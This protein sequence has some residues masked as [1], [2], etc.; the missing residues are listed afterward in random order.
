MKRFWALAR[1]NTLMA[2][3]QMNFMQRRRPGRR[4][5]RG[6]L[7]GMLAVALVLMAY[8]TFWA[9][10][11]SIALNP[12]GLEWVIL[13]IGLVIITVLVLTLSMFTLDS[14][15][16]DNSDT[17]TLFAYP[18]TKFT[19]V[20]GKIGGLLVQN[21]CVVAVLWLPYVGVYA[22]YAHP[23]VLFYFFALL[24]L[25]IT[26]GVPLFVMGLISYVVGLVT[27]GSRFRK[28][29]SIVLTLALIIVII[30]G[31][32]AAIPVLEASAGSEVFGLLQHMYPP[33][34]WA[35]TALAHESVGAMGL[36]I[37]WN[38]LPFVALCGLVSLS[39]AFIRS[40][41]ASVKKPRH[42]RRVTFGQTP[43]G[44]ALLRKELSRLVFSPVYLMN[45]CVGVVVLLLL[46]ILAG[47]LGS[48]LTTVEDTLT[49]D[50]LPIARLILVFVLFVLC[51][52]N[53]TASSIS[54]EGRSLWIV[55]SAPIGAASVLRA[56]L[57]VQ[58]VAIAPLVVIA[59]GVAIFTMRIGLSGFAT[60]AVP[61]VLFTLVSSCV[62]LLYNLHVYRL[63][64]S[65]DMQAVRNSAPVMMTMGTMFAV[66]AVSTLGF[67]FASHFQVLGFW[68]YWAI[69]VGILAVAVVVLYRHLMTR[70]VGLFE[71]L[72]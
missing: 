52:A 51:I 48:S 56:K 71:A 36:A 34:G 27:S 33:L 46:A 72:G 12:I 47:R 40:R 31:V 43:T 24:C 14:L 1:V 54:L 63:D 8:M 4:S 65:N 16:F 32:H 68:A 58:A 22:Y 59:S 66:V 10:M 39:Y 30:F 67:V 37:L 6:F 35:I 70:G 13:P 57:G 7:Y 61:A 62:G 53:T 60:I 42:A 38:V 45:S 50:G 20:A 15:L 29:Y 26:P 49:A 5:G 44:K 69:W 17:D 3:Y 28:V 64:Y 55:K 41:V 9:V 19:V 11:L 18:V 25:L 23:G 21:W 2:L